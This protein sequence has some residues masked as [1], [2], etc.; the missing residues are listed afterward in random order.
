MVA[1]LGILLTLLVINAVLLIF[2]VNG[3]QKRSSTPIQ[4]VTQTLHPELA[5]HSTTKSE[6]TEAV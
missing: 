4:K 1:F 6:Y 2:S 3:D 5:S